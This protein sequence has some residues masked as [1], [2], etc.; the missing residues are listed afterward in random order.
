MKHLLCPVLLC[1]T[2]VAIF[3]GCGRKGVGELTAAEAKAFDQAAPELKQEWI[4]ALEASKTN[5]YNGAQTLLYG[6][7]NQ[8]LSP[9]QRQAVVKQS[10]VVN[11]RLYSALEKGDP[12]AQKA[13]E[14]MRRN[15]PN[16]P[17]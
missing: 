6:L 12:A 11:D 2:S 5:D 17:H 15:P 1:L 3:A 9:E 13:I 8:N 16:R 4:A 10:T 7:L 14:E